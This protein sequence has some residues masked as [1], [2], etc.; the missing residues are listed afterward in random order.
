MPLPLATKSGQVFGRRL[1]GLKGKLKTLKMFK[2]KW[3]EEP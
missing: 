3:L 2:R 1:L